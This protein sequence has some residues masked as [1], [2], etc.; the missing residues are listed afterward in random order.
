[1][2]ILVSQLFGDIYVKMTLLDTLRFSRLNERNREEAYSRTGPGGIFI[3]DTARHT[4]YSFNSMKYDLM[5]LS[6]QIMCFKE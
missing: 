6:S 3:R 4:A 2:L 1:M 5:L